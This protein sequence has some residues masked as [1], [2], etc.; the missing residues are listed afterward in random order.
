MTTSGNRPRSPSWK[1][2]LALLSLV[3]SLLLW[4]GG[5]LDSLQR[6]SVGNA[7]SQRQL[8]LAALAAPQLPVQ[9]KEALV[10][11]VPER[12]L[13]DELN[14]Q[15]KETSTAGTPE[16]SANLLQRAL[17]EANFGR[18]D[19]ARDLYRQLQQAGPPLDQRPLVEALLGGDR[20]PSERAELLSA[21]VSHQE[22]LHQLACQQLL[23]P[24]PGAPAASCRNEAA[25]RTAAVQLVVVNVLPAFALLLGLALLVREL[26]QRWR[27]KAPAA[28]ALLAP[29]LT[30]VDVTLLVAGG[31]VVLGDLVTPLVIRPPAE[32]LLRALQIGSPLAE[33]LSVVIFYLGLMSCPLLILALMLRSRV[34]PE[35]GWLQFRWQ[36]L[37]LNLRRAFKGFLMVLPLVSLV[38]WL[39]SLLLG[40]PGGSNPL[41]ELVLQSD[42]LPT[43]LC[44]ALTA[45]VLAP[46][47]EEAIFRGVLLPVL[48]REFGMG[49]GI[50]ASSLVFGVAHLSLGELPPLFV[51]GLG[52]GWLRWSSGRLGACVLMHGLWNAIT[53]TNLVVLGS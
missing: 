21:P 26:W 39:Q 45:V 8:E 4:V 48:G 6:P 2:V 19:A 51:L 18:S 31:F 22:L 25:E 38:G 28:P 46:L 17:L 14:R 49:W 30:L 37:G 15:A 44:F 13:L 35:G 10:G 40:D 24:G 9:L 33:G 36:P 32:A 20:L 5:L 23:K 12:Q 16:S 50:M 34:P 27:G 52:L 42:N 53:F 29:P 11:A 41:L 47:F 1:V 43:L 3:L 7:L